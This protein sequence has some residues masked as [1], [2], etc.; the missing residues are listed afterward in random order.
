LDFAGWLADL[1]L[2]VRKFLTIH[3]VHA[4]RFGEF[5][6]IGIPDD[7]RMFDWLQEA[8]DDLLELPRYYVD[9]LGLRSWDEVVAHVRAQPPYWWDD[10]ELR[11]AAER[12]FLELISAG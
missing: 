12:K 4:V 7:E 5:E 2:H 11:R 9:R 8:G 3:A 1:L 6:E 10:E